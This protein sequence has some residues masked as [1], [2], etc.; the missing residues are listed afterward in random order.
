MPGVG[1]LGHDPAD[2]SFQVFPRGH[3]GRSERFD[4]R[5][6]SGDMLVGDAQEEAVFVAVVVVERRLRKPARLRD[7]VHRRRRVALAGKELRGLVPDRLTLIVVAGRPTPCHR[8][9]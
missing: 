8:L 9:P 4:E 5:L 6:Q 2:Q 3:G 7:L 1:V